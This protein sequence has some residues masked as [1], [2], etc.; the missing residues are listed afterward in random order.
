MTDIMI[1]VFRVP[2]GTRGPDSADD[3]VALMRAEA[4]PQV[5][6][7]T[8]EGIEHLASAAIGQFVQKAVRRL[9][10]AEERIP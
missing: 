4:A 6:T 10:E 8:R 1:V 9:D 7:I 5:I 3:A 2:E